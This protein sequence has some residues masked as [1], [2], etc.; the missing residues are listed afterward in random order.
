M[1]RQGGATLEMVLR[2]QH[3]HEFLLVTSRPAFLRPTNHSWVQS[4]DS[5]GIV[6]NVETFS[7]YL[8]TQP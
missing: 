7:C 6:L 2:E 3:G 5:I 4:C 1:N 8:G